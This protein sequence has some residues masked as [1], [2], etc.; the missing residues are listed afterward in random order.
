[1]TLAEQLDGTPEHPTVPIKPSVPCE[2]PVTIEKVS[3]SPSASEPVRE[4][5]FA[6]SSVAE[7]A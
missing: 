1:M 6:T 3:A 4:I 2:G 5:V 7:T